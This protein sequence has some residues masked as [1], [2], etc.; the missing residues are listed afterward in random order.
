MLFRADFLRQQPK[1]DLGIQYPECKFRP[2]HNKNEDKTRKDRTPVTMEDERQGEE[3]AQLLF[4][5][6]KG[7]ELLLLGIWRVVEVRN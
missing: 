2:A 5:E 1:T 4:E 6:T 7:E 3:V